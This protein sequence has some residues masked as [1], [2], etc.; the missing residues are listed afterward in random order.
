[1]AKSL[2]L[3]H[4]RLELESLQ[5]PVTIFN[6]KLDQ[7][8]QVFQRGTD[9][10]ESEYAVDEKDKELFRHTEKLSYAMGTGE[11]G[12]GYLIQRGDFLFQAPLA[13]YARTKS[14]ELSPGFEAQ[15]FGFGRPVTDGCIICHS[16]LP[17]PLA[18]AKGLFRN[19]PFRE[20]GIGCENCHGPGQLHVEERLRG[21]R[22]PADIDSTIVNP[23]KLPPWLASNICMYCHEQGDARVLNPGK[24]FVDF[25]PGTPLAHTI[26]IFNISS[27]HAPEQK[28]TFLGYYSGMKASKCYLMSRGRLNCLTCHDPHRQLESTEASAS[29]R[30]KCLTC[31]SNQ[32]CKLPLQT[33]LREEPSDSC[34]KCHMANLTTPV[35]A[36]TVT[37]DHHITARPGEPY[38]NSELSRSS[39]DA[40]DLIYVD[41]AAGEA[42]PL[43]VPL[44]L[45]AYR[46]LLLDHSDPVYELNYSKLL[47]KAAK[48]DPQNIEVLRGLAKRGLQQ[49]T[50][51]GILKALPYL[52]RIV[53]SG[54]ATPDDEFALG[55][56]L[57]STGEITQGI[58]LLQK[59]VPIDPYNP[60]G[61]E[62]LAI[63]Y[64]VA[65]RKSDAVKEIQ[66]GLDLNP[67]NQ[68]LRLMLKK[69]DE[70]PR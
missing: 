9:F 11:N 62:S 69:A 58:S 66:Q 25:R 6:V 22:V 10:W 31:H 15:S 61:C 19:P 12:V 46:Q 48:T 45:A 24:N 1:M 39:P 7:Y 36:H 40:P 27:T 44:L 26:A 2:S 51:E 33:R 53:A 18:D 28:L 60:L 23:A 5:A 20:L 32:S 35:F 29:Y 49:G 47:D 59:T 41:P 65:G 17:Q 37:T 30:I 38:P 56:L 67:E 68:V 14:W 42:A 55:E 16:G 70:G 13:F 52:K 21:K 4:E 43:P 34:V 54:L 8:F 57:A 63:S 50:A 3:P 64:W